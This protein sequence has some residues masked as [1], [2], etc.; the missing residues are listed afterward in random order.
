M[1]D[2]KSHLSR[3]HILSQLELETAAAAFWFSSLKVS[4]EEECKK[5]L[6]KAARMEFDMPMPTFKKSKF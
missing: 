3:Q 4:R 1:V 6:G 5:N 2:V